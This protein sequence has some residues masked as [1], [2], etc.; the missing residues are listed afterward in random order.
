MRWIVQELRPH[1]TY[2]QPGKTPRNADELGTGEIDGF[3][4]LLIKRMPQYRHE[5]V[6][7]PFARYELMARHGETI[8]SLLH[9]RTQERLSWLYFTTLY[10][11][12]ESRQIYVVMRRDQAFAAEHQGQSLSMTELLQRRDLVGLLPRDRSFGPRID[13]ALREAPD[14]APGT[15]VAGRNLHLLAML[16]AHRMDYTLEYGAVVDDFER[17]GGRQDFVKLP[18]QEGRST[19]VATAACSRTPEGR[20]RIEAIDAAVR[21]L[22]QEPQ[23]DAWMRSWRGDALDEGDRQRLQRYMDERARQGPQIE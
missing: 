12:L 15:I 5:L 3:L 2:V 4:R 6:E 16:R 20:E 10:P 7:M 19:T 13:A 21:H 1:F 11:P 14:L 9:V 17:Q 18:L 8:C 22:A 23:R